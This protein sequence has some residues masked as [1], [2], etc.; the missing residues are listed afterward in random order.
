MEEKELI[1]QLKSL[2]MI[3]PR[4]EWVILTKRRIL[5]EEKK[6]SFVLDIWKKL[7]TPVPRPALVVRGVMVLTL[8]VIG[9]FAYYFYLNLN[10]QLQWEN[11]QLISLRTLLKENQ[12]NQKFLSTLEQLQARLVKVNSSLEN[13]KY[14]RN[15][16]QALVMTEVVKATATKG[17]EVVKGMKKTIPPSYQVLATLSELDETFD[18]LEQKSSSL[19]REMIFSYLQDLKQRSLSKQ[20]QERLEKAEEYAK[21]GKESEAM[22]LIMKIGNRK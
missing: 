3:K 2:Q 21:E 9:I 5:G 10:S 11:N 13:L 8:L 14:S 15:Q 4:K 16:K 20:D 17:K 18:E 6:Q 7:F 1:R 22:I 12:Q 19:Q